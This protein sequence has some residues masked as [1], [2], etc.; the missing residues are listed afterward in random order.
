MSDRKSSSWFY[1]KPTGDP[2]RDRNARTLQFACFLLAFA[3]SLVAVLNTDMREGPLLVFA[4]AGLVAAAVINRAG[5]PAFA[6]RIAFLAVLLTA[7]LLVLEARDGFRSN[8]MLVFPGLLLIGVMLLD[9]ASYVTTAG[10]VLVAVAALGVAE[11]HGFTRAIPGV[12]TPTNYNSIFFVDLYLLVVALIGSR[13]VRDT[14]RN[15][16]DLH[17]SVDRISAKNREL[18]ESA[19]ALRVSEAK[20]RRLHESITDAVLTFDM[21]GHLLEFNPAFEA[22]LGYTAEELRRLTYQ[23]ITPERWHAFEARILAE[24][25]LPNGHSAVYEEEY[26]RRDGS[27]F[28]VE[29]RTYLLRNEGGQPRGMWAIVRDISERR[30]DEQAI[31]EGEQRLRIA[32]DAAKLG[33]YDYDVATGTIL[34]DARVRQLWGVA[35]DAPVTIDTFF[36]GLHAEDRSKTQ[37]LLERALDPAG[38]GEYYAEYRVISRAD[39]SERWVAATGQ[40]FFE[41]GR[42]VHMIGTGQDISERK[43]AEAELRESEERFRNMADTAPVMIWVTGPDKLCTFV[44]RTWLNFTGRTMEQELGNGWP[45]CVHPDDRQRNY[46]VFSS[47]FDARQR[48]QWS[49]GGAGR[50]EN[51]GWFCAPASRGS[52]PEAILP[53]ISALRSISRTCRAK[54]GSGSWRKTSI[55]FSGCSTSA[56]SGRSMSA[57]PSRRFGG[58]VPPPCI[59]TPAGW[60]IPSTPRTGIAL[61]RSS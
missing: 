3:I 17:T 1:P 55:R 14:Q 34:W 45:S 32:K 9:R 30:R 56:H 13:I 20:Y 8:A 60:S 37:A 16:A 38:N 28:P 21:A 24:Q 29:L 41:D 57:L 10:I 50:T 53:A 6:A 39:G 46:E 5:M 42:A 40:V 25:V 2:G 61:W 11:K 22:M 12:R 47:A 59:K 44:N 27:V 54:S 33:I 36:L 18:T 7:V 23:D 31:S 51:T 52:P 35:P 48:F 43:R 49:R 15:A 4:V 58:L 19:E 26:R